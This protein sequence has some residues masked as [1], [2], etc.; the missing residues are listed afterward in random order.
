VSA[1]GSMSEESRVYK[2]L[3]DQ[4]PDLIAWIERIGIDHRGVGI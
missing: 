2:R 3:A 1:L 4:F